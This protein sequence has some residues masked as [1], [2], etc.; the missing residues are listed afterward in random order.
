M[1]APFPII[2]REV[3]Y[4]DYFV[5][6]SVHLLRYLGNKR[7]S[8]NPPTPRTPSSVL[9]ASS[10][11]HLL[12]AVVG[13]VEQGLDEVE[14]APGGQILVVKVRVRLQQYSTLAKVTV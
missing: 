14:A 1:T 8:I 3:T 2:R 9:S 7:N 6:P 11:D 5:R 13:K 12:V 4:T 10:T